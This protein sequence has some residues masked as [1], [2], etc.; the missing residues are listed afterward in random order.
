A[1]QERLYQYLRPHLE[2]RIPP[3]PPK[4]LPKLK[5]IIPEGL[6][7]MVRA[8]ASLEHVSPEAKAELG[9][10]I[11]ERIRTAPEAGGP[12]AWALGRLGA[13][14]PLHGSGHKTVP[15]E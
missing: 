1:Q 13:R 3:E 10:W 9:G 4:G 7:E 11:V 8:A 15:P 2:R 14:A 5:G 12:W 6:D